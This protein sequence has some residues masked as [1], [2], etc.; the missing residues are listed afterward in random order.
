[1]YEI[2]DRL[3]MKKPHPCGGKEWQIVR[4]GA[5][6]KLQCLTCGKY[7]NITRDEL[8]RR[9]KSIARAQTSAR[10]TEA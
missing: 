6:L 7:L 1:M 5:D 8:K 10:A 3:T 4:I 2:N 9:T